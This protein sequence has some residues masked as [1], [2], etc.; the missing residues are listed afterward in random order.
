MVGMIVEIENSRH[1]NAHESPKERRA[2][3]VILHMFLN[4]AAQPC[5]IVGVLED[6][7]TLWCDVPGDGVTEPMERGEILLF[8]V[9]DFRLA[10]V[11]AD[12]IASM[13]AKEKG[14]SVIHGDVKA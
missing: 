3:G 12:V 9:T 14:L 10:P 11:P 2:N 1:F 8:K 5:W 13:A 6:Y 7:Q 4:E